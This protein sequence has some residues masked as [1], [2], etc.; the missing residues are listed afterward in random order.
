M[1]SKSPGKTQMDDECWKKPFGLCRKATSGHESKKVFDLLDKNV[2]GH[3]RRRDEN[4]RYRLI[5][6]RLPGTL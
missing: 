4:K 1:K 5:L 6:F 3:D 2:V